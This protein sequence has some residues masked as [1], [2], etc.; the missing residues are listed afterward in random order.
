MAESLNLRISPSLRSLSWSSLH[1]PGGITFPLPTV[2]CVYAYG[3]VRRVGGL[4]VDI[5]WKYVGKSSNL[6]RRARY[7]HDIDRE[8][9][10]QLRTWLRKSS[11][12]E[13]WYALVPMESLDT[14]ETLLIRELRPE[15]NVRKVVRA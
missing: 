11:E 9:N 4:P 14:I 13:L 1:L 8:E 2:S 7:G 3:E 5:A 6:R 15:F 12:A 10:V